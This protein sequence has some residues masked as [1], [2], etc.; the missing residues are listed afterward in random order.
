MI[1]V[2]QHQRRPGGTGSS[3][4]WLSKREVVL[5]GGREPKT[6][7]R[8]QRTRRRLR[9]A[10]IALVLERGWERTTV[11]DVCDRADVGCSTFY[12]HFQ[13]KEKLLTQALTT[14][15]PRFVPVRL[16]RQT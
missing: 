4:A 5:K 8:V 11:Q 12:L 15:V 7:R 10:L 16:R 3:T 13:S 6:N 9:E 2:N 1:Q 14:S